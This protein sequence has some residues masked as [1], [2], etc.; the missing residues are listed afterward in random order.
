MLKDEITWF[1]REFWKVGIG[2]DACQAE[3]GTRSW[4][5]LNYPTRE[6]GNLDS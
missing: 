2:K 1:I 6:I 4:R 3:I 5:E